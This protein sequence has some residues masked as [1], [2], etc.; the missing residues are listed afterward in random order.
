ME[1]KH[2]NGNFETVREIDNLRAENARLS[3]IVEYIAMMADVEIPTAEEEAHREE[4]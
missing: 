1:V 4:V 2:N 3:A